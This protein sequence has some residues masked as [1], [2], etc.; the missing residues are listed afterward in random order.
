M[1][2]L[3]L[4]ELE[5]ESSYTGREFFLK[6]PIMVHLESIISDLRK[7][8]AEY[9]EMIKNLSKNPDYLTDSYMELS[10]LNARLKKLQEEYDDLQFR[11]Q[12]L[13]LNFDEK[14]DGAKKSIQSGFIAEREHLLAYK[15]IV[16]AVE[17]YAKEYFDRHFESAMEDY[18]DCK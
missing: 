12:E 3:N 16:D 5:K 2:L 15:N 6:P 14:L 1:V 13:A 9:A 8:N 4:E 18:D 7:Q 17:S 10:L 11:F